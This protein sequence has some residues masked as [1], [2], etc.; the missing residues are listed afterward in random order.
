M[1]KPLNSIACALTLLAALSASA[2]AQRN[3][4]RV[5]GALEHSPPPVEYV[6]TQAMNQSDTVVVARIAKIVTHDV[7]ESYPAQHVVALNI[8][9][10]Q[11]IKG[12]HP[13]ATEPV[14]LHT[15]FEA[16]IPRVGDSVLL[17]INRNVQTLKLKEHNAPPVSWSIRGIAQPTKEN[18]ARATRA[19]AEPVGWVLKDGSVKAP[20]VGRRSLRVGPHVQIDVE[21]VA[22]EQDV[23]WSNPFGDGKFKITVTNTSKEIVTVPALLEKGGEILWDESL[24]YVHLG[25]AH[26][27][28]NAKGMPADANP[29]RIAP[30]YSVSTVV[31][32]LPIDYEGWAGGAREQ[33]TFAIGDASVT[34]FFYYQRT[35]HDPMRAEA[36]QKLGK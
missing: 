13:G 25:Q 5:A 34:S 3:P 28:P 6:T 24:L 26:A 11:H 18:V 9:V 17:G 4:E 33:F 8:D 22:P 10:T 30:G 27:M 1:S 7:L 31:D 32:M 15:I 20:I 2:Q 12:R 35:Y 14:Y 23:K 19:S 36:R 29:A 16:E 21:Q